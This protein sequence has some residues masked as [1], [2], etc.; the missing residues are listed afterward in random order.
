MELRSTKSVPCQLV[1]LEIFPRLSS[2]SD[3]VQHELLAVPFQEMLMHAIQMASRPNAVQFPQ[4]LLTI[5]LLAVD[6]PTE[7]HQ[8]ALQSILQII[9]Q[10]LQQAK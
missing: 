1:L 8:K 10:T 2:F 4:A 3:V 9:L 5:G 7:V 6:R